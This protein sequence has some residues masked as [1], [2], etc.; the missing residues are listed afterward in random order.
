VTYI[1]DNIDPTWRPFVVTPSF[2]TYTSG[3]STQ[4]GA[5]AEVLTQMFGVR[6]FVDT[7]RYDHDLGQPLLTR[8][9]RSFDAAAYEA[10]VSRLYGGIH[11]SFDNNDGLLAGRCIGH[12]ISQKV[13][14]RVVRRRR[15]D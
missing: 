4:S 6:R 7:I 5:A 10:A 11:Y 3:H 9:F 12:T 14:F 1:R 13:R 8:S 2:P 15:D